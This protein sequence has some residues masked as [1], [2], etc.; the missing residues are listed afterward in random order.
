MATDLGRVAVRPRAFNQGPA[1]MAIAGLGDASLEAPWATG[2]FRGRQAQITHQLFGVGQARE[3]ASCGDGRDR[4]GELYTPQRLEGL[5]YRGEAPR[6]DPF[7]EFLF[8]T[9]EACGVFGDS[10]HILLEDD[11]LGWRQTDDFREP[12]E[13]CGAP[14]GL[15]RIA[16]VLAQEKGFQ[17]ILRSFEVTDAILTGATQIANGFV[18]DLGDVDGGEVA[19]THQPG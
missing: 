16:N 6:F 13:M 1:G 7:L 2:R 18:I 4:H 14:I 19:R 12:S 15:A 9:L 10:P 17:A 5:N 3:V 11:L 8:Q